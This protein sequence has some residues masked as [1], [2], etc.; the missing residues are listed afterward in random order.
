M[1]SMSGNSAIPTDARTNPATTNG[2]AAAASG[3]RAVRRGAHPRHEEKEQDVVDRHDRADGG[4]PIAEHVR[5]RGGTNVL[6]SGPVTPAKRPPSPTSR[7]VRYG[8]R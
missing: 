8:A 7:M 4:A 2:S 6:S 1:P 3:A 5:T